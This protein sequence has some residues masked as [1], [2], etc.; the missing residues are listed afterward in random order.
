M[1]LQ[2]YYICFKIRFATILKLIRI[3]LLNVKESFSLLLFSLSLS[4]Y[5]DCGLYFNWRHFSFYT[6]T[7]KIRT[8]F[9][10]LIHLQFCIMHANLNN[11]CT[12]KINYLHFLSIKNR[13]KIIFHAQ[14]LAVINK[15][16]AQKL[17]RSANPN[18][19]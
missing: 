11:I 6:I 14:G 3:N 9:L 1:V 4:L 8:M 16:D 7:H 15:T 17:I 10:L 19:P 18:P 13:K 12:E 5:E 2:L